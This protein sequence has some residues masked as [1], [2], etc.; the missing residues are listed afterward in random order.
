[1]AAKPKMTPEQWADVRAAWEADPRKALPWLI[2]ELGLPVS[3]EAL[4][5]RSKSEGWAKTPPVSGEHDETGG[6]PTH[7][8]TEFA[9]QA[10]N[11]C[12]LGAD[13]ARLAEFFEVT[14]RTINR[15]KKEH[16]EFAEALRLGKTEAD[17]Q[18]AQSLFQR[19]TGCSHPDVHVSNYQGEI[20]LTP[21][22]KH[23]PPDVQAATFWLKNR[24]PHHW[25]ERVEVKAE[26]KGDLFP[27]TEVLDAIHAKGLAEAA[28]REKMLRG[29]RERLG[30]VVEPYSS[31]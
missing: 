5:Q 31:A 10:K 13:D 27:P 24:Q 1:M 29:R 3:A 17:A 25:K 18:V 16:P 11:Y 12:L 20:T 9:A 22:T 4:R 7:Y 6:R 23:Y 21:I 30:I 19:A 14:E 28:E 26:I 2:Q 8:R 15:W